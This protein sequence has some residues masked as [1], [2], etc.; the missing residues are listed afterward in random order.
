MINNF[1]SAQ[2]RETHQN[3]PIVV[4]I[5][6]DIL[7]DVCNETDIVRV[8]LNT[9]AITMFEHAMM[10][11]E[12]VPSRPMI[13]DFLTVLFKTPAYISSQE[14]RW[15]NE[16]IRIRPDS[17]KLAI[18]FRNFLRLVLSFRT[19]IISNLKTLTTKNLSYYA[20]FFF[21][22]M[23]KLVRINARCVSE[24]LPH[25]EEQVRHVEQLRNAGTDARLR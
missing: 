12:N 18:I 25:I 2:R 7:N 11:D 10:V 14:I 20:S 9:T 1:L 15:G 19:I 6:T 24:I 8:L 5:L 4:T 22:F 21:Q 23:Q 13:F 17:V 16:I 3:A